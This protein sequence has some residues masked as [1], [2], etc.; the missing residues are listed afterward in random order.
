[1][2]LEAG[3][4]L[5]TG[6]SPDLMNEVTTVLNEIG[7]AL[8]RE[9]YDA[10]LALVAAMQKVMTVL[11]LVF[12]F[13]GFGAFRGHG[14]G[15]WAA[16]GG[17]IVNLLIFLPLGIAGIYA[18]I[19]PLPAD[20]DK[21]ERDALHPEPVSHI[22][23]FVASILVMLYLRSYLT[24]F[25]RGLGLPV[26]P[27]DS[28]PIEWLIAGQLGFTLFHELGHLVLAWGVGFRFQAM[29]V[30]PVTVTRNS[31][32][33]WRFGFDPS[34][35][36]MGGGYLQSVPGSTKDLRL[37]WILIVIAGPMASLFVGL[38]GFL[39]LINIAGTAYA[40]YWYIAVYVS[41]ICGSDFVA[42]MMPLGQADGAMLFHALFKTKKGK[43]ILGSLE[44]SMLADRADRESIDMDP[45]QLLET[46][47]KA[48]E[49]VAKNKEVSPLEVACHK[50]EFARASIIAGR[51]AEAADILREAGKVLETTPNLPSIIWFR[52]F[53]DVYEV[54][55][56]TGRLTTAIEARDKA[57]DLEE[58]LDNAEVDWDTALALRVECVKLRISDHDLHGARMRAE[59]IRSHCPKRKSLTPERAQLL[60]LQGECLIR[61]GRKKEGQELLDE[62]VDEI[63]DTSGDRRLLGNSL[64]VLGQTA[65]RMAEA[66]DLE[67][68]IKLFKIAVPNLEQNGFTVRAKAFRAVWAEALYNNNLFDEALAVIE[69]LGKELSGRFGRDVA[70]LRASL[71]LAEGNPSEALSILEPLTMA[72]SDADPTQPARSRSLRSWALYKMGWFQDA[73]A[74]ARRA[75]DVLMPLEHYEAAHA[76]L[77]L[78]LAV[79]QE[80]R[81]LGAAYLDEATRVISQSGQLVPA[82]KALRLEEIARQLQ[83]VQRE[84]E[85][86]LVLQAAEEFRRS[87]AAIGQ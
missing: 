83:S 65:S 14:W 79:W 77:T 42:N 82:T 66:G 16:I 69:P 30:G 68:G 20:P 40:S 81:D 36:L 56:A 3:A 24:D 34:K 50:L 25:A 64:E 6:L 61:T 78:S 7:S 18:N 15:R 51:N 5:S 54:E 76:L 44:A 10:V 49:S 84:Q 58:R 47:R 45:E 23:I 38:I 27:G 21:A 13:A 31:S 87:P 22:I 12:A 2:L 86:K 19:K 53:L 70:S 62:A 85:S 26:N 73:V 41:A 17:S 11:G 9:Q 28:L 8:P 52:Y 43:A 72:D 80:N 4:F 39:A 71:Y 74:E 55:L 57:L 32:G 67:T 29:N 33:D 75:C 48:L 63:L 35:I 59:A 1:M 60:A 37:N 46:R